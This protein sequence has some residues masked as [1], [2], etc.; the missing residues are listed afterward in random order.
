MEARLH[1]HKILCD[2]LGS[3][4]VYFQPPESVKLQYPAIIYTCDNLQNT[5][6]DDQVYLQ[7]T[8]YQVTVVDKDPDSSIA[9]QISRLP[10]CKFVRHYNSENLNHFVFTLYGRIHP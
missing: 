3:K 6:A 2:I 9:A 1:L 8:A 4:H 7:H 5:F 10:L